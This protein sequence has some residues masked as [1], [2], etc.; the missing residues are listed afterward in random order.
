MPFTNEYISPEDAAKYHL[1]EIDAKFGGGNKS[2]DWTIDRQRGIYLRNLGVGR[3]EEFRHHTYWTFYWKG[4]S[5]T[6]RLDLLEVTGNPGGAAWLHWRLVDLNGSS[7]LPVALKE[8]R[9]SILD[10]LKQALVAQG[11]GG[12]DSLSTECSVTLD[13]DGG[14]VL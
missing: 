13:F 6:L 10:D 3:E 14:C 4:T 11:D 2:R 7:G 1:T 12:V 8:H 9:Q 5:F